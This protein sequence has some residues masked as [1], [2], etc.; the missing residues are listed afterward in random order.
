MQYIKFMKVDRVLTI[1]GSVLLYYELVQ[2]E[3]QSVE[4]NGAHQ[5]SVKQNIQ[6]VLFHM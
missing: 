2:L 5:S 4:D 1:S 3:P 6:C